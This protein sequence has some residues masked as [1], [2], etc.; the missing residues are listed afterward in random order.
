MLP[1][2]ADE[3]AEVGDRLDLTGHL[4]APVEVLGELLPRVGLALLEAQRD[5]TTLFVHIQHHDL[6][7]L[8]GVHHLRRVDVL[9]RPVHL[10][11]VDET[12]DAI[13]DLHER[14][15]V[16]D[17]RDLAEHAGVR[18]VTAGNVLPRI[19]TQLLQAQA[20]ARTLAV[21]LEDAHVD[22]VADLDDF[23]R[24]LDALP[25]HVRDVQQ[26]VDATEIHERTVVGE[27][28][29][30]AL[31]DRAFL[32]VVH[33][34][35][36]LCGELLLDDGTTRNDDVIALLI[37]LDDLELERL[38]LEV[39]RVAHRAH[40]HERARQ[41][42]AD[43]LDLDGEATLHATRDDAGDDLGTVE[44]SLEARPRAGTLG[45]LAGQ[46]GFPGA[47]FHGVQRDFDFVARLHF[48]LAPFVLELVDTD[49]GLGLEAHVD[50]D[51][52]VG[53]FDDEPGQDHAGANALV[54]ET[55]FE[56][57]SETFSHTFTSRARS[58]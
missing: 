24:M 53:D 57:L 34:S 5:A 8:A 32:Q 44:G 23:R 37:E 9:V 12:F 25:R 43:I 31:D 49:D 51:H 39:R 47:V 11:H 15:V 3:D 38:V 41:E 20:D 27:V 19:R 50:D 7:F 18:R 45:L 21:E 2:Q 4:V 42:R 26:A 54:S 1:R 40:V 13:L 48:D 14:A 55:F 6:D 17:V 56:K 16:G 36:A 35:A 30:R 46:A 28:L 33:E 58:A 22:L 52:V 10:G 29:D